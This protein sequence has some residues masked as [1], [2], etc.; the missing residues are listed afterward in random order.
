MMRSEEME[1][2]AWHT[3]E[4]FAYFGRA[5]YLATCLETGLAQALLFAEFLHGV[6]EKLLAEGGLES[7]SQ[8]AYELEFDAYMEKQFAQ[9]LG[10]II[11]KIE[12]L[13][14]ISDELRRRIVTAKKRRDFLTHYFWRE[15]AME[16]A[17]TKGR[18]AMR[19]ELEVDMEAFEKLDADVNAALRPARQRLGIKEEWL[20]AHFEKVMKQLAEQER[21]EGLTDA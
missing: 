21:L 16:F 14:E 9:T 11:R 20:Q 8:S 5:F 19:G 10:N 15:R 18:S 3:R 7:F 4:T 12:K 17:T 1:E 6:K 2:D 13:P